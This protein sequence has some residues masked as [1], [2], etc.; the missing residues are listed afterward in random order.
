MFGVIIIGAGPAGI[1][2]LS[3]FYREGL[4]RGRL[5]CK[6]LL[7][8]QKSINRTGQLS[9]YQ[10]PSD[11]RAEKF[12]T[13]LDNIPVDILSD[14]KLARLIQALKSYGANA[15]PLPI[16]GD[17][18]RRLGEL[19]CQDMIDRDWLEL[20]APAAVSSAKWEDNHWQVTAH[21]NDNPLILTGRNIVLACGAEETKTRLHNFLSTHNLKAGDLPYIC[22]SSDVLKASPDNIIFENLRKKSHPRVAIIGGSHSAISTAAKLLKQDIKFDSYGINILHRSPMHV[23][24]DSA[25]VAREEYGFTEF[26]ARDICP[27]TKRVFALKGF[28]LDSRD[29]LLAIKGYGGGELETRVLLAN[30]QTRES[31]VPTALKDAD[32]IVSALGYVPEYI[33]LY[34]Q[35]GERLS[36]NAPNFVDERSRLLDQSQNPIGNCYALGLASNYNLAGRFGEPSFKGQANG[37]VLWHKDIGEEIVESTLERA[38]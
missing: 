36:L 24:F 21:I 28:R 27:K 23:T 3:C 7:L 20:H 12:L 5:P 26:S 16:V 2:L 15:I 14:S 37:L 34:G 4:K 35:D 22:L 31:F 19:I 33:P 25:E 9:D 17:F 8:D 29:L 1:G 18:Y 13:C 30:I 38:A 11:T 10:I 6:I 32:L